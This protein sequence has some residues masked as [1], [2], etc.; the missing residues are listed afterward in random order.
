[1]NK[2]KSQPIRLKPL[3]VTLGGII[4]LT[5]V[6]FASLVGILRFVN[7]SQQTIFL[8]IA[9]TL[10][11]Y[12]FVVVAFIVLM[13][14]KRAYSW[15]DLGFRKPQRNLWNLVWQLPLVLIGLIVVQ[16]IVS[17]L[18]N[19]ESSSQTGGVDDLAKNVPLYAALL[20]CLSTAIL[21]PIWEEIVFRGIIH[22]YLTSKMKVVYTALLSS[23]IF[24]GIHVAPILFPYLFMMGLAWTWL[25]HRYNTLWAPIL[26]H[27][28]INTLATVTV[29]IY[30][31]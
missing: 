23:A 28:F 21:T 11:G 12:S 6:I 9:L 27:T 15:K 18:L 30:L 10:T 19:T 5:I 3:F 1:M 29:F 31:L 4:A 22:N 20:I 13:V 7:P 25:Y 8:A 24:A 14:K 17:A 16:A 26:G 2:P